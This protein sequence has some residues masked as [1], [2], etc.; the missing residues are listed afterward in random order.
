MKALGVFWGPIKTLSQ[1][2][3]VVEAVRLAYEETRKRIDEK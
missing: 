3:V 2:D 1:A